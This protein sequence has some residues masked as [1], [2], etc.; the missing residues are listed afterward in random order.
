MDFFKRMS[1]WCPFSRAHLIIDRSHIGVI[2]RFVIDMYLI[3][4]HERDLMIT[5]WMT[6]VHVH[7]VPN[8]S[9]AHDWEVWLERRQYRGGHGD[10]LGNV[11]ARDFANFDSTFIVISINNHFSNFQ[12]CC[13][14]D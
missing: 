9:L 5:T 13:L 14:H 12:V 7:A 10:H 6:N 4:L 8:S 1:F 2:L 3:T 11:G